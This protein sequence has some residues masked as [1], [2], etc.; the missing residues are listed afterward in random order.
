MNPPTE[1]LADGHE[2]QCSLCYQRGIWEVT[3]YSGCDHVFC[4]ACVN[5][6]TKEDHLQC[7]FCREHA[8]IRVVQCQ[9]CQHM[10]PYFRMRFYYNGCAHIV[11]SACTSTTELCPVARQ[12]KATTTRS[13]RKSTPKTGCYCEAPRNEEVLLV[14]EDRTPIDGINIIKWIA[15]G[16]AEI[17]K[18]QVTSDRKRKI[19]SEI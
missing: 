15:P 2:L 5:A 6:W 14:K 13:G 4:Y 19:S 12:I 16:E 3:P 17:W 10:F 11:C 1:T 18:T 8:P 9:V 7:P